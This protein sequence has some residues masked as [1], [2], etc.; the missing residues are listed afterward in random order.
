MRDDPESMEVTE[1]KLPLPGSTVRRLDIAPDGRIWFVNSS[2]GRIGR[3]DPTTG[4]IKEWDSP[5]GPKSHP[6][7]MAVVDGI[8]W[9]NESGVRPDML[10]RFDPVTESFQSWPVPTGRIYAG[11]IRH[12][13]PTREGNLL[14]HQTSTNRIGMVTV[15][16]PA[17]R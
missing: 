14:I 5:S 17:V 11:I 10:V 4:E 3:L 15:K 7:A 2:L 13:R 9:Y 16:E 12:M 8:V 6:Y 1:Y